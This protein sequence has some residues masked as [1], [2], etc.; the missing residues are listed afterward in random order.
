MNRCLYT[1]NK[2]AYRNIFVFFRSKEGSFCIACAVF[3]Q[4][5]T[6]QGRDLR[7]ITQRQ[8]GVVSQRGRHLFDR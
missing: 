6:E 8:G 2:S 1:S 7:K 5:N 4:M 3:D